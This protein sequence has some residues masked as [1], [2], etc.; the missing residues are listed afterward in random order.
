MTGSELV[1][2][3]PVDLIVRVYECVR[4]EKKETFKVL[5]ACRDVKLNGDGHVGVFT[6]LKYTHLK[7]SR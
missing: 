4:K 6:T 2:S 7:K 3:L 5:R 1:K